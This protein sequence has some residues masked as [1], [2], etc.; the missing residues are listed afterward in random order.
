MVKR[1]KTRKDYEESVEE[2]KANVSEI[3]VQFRKDSDKFDKIKYIKELTY[4]LWTLVLG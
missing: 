2:V 4:Q 3:I 1:E